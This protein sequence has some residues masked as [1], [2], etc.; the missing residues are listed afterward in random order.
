MESQSCQETV[1]KKGYTQLREMP[2]SPVPVVIASMLI[3]SYNC[4]VHA[5]KQPEDANEM[6]VRRIWRIISGF[7]AGVVVSCAHHHINR[8]LISGLLVDRAAVQVSASGE[9]GQL[10]SV[11]RVSLFCSRHSGERHGHRIAQSSRMLTQTPEIFAVMLRK[12][13]T[14]NGQ[15]WP[16]MVN[17][18]ISN[19]SLERRNGRSA[20]IDFSVPCQSLSSSETPGLRLL[21][22]L[23]GSCLSCSTGLPLH[24][25]LL[26][27]L[28]YHRCII[29]FLLFP[30]SVAYADN[31]T[32][33]GSRLH[34][35]TNLL[36]C[37]CWQGRDGS[38]GQCD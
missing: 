20:G 5:Y 7:S 4:E 33:L 3:K 35:L 25:G 26:F 10:T 8:N 38:I 17:C 29:P 21:K 18:I 36:M 16:C 11:R 19:P 32:H 28:A 9:A 23:Q 31:Y 30:S 34:D 15:H 1:R 27:F 13:C 2:S 6:R 14:M 12:V 22:F 37:A 24:I